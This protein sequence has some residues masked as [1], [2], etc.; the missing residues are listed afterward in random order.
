MPRRARSERRTF[1]LLSGVTSAAPRA[2]CAS[3][4]YPSWT[5]KRTC[6]KSGLRLG[7]RGERRV[8]RAGYVG[9]GAL[10]LLRADEE[11]GRGDHV[12]LLGALVVCVDHR[13]REVL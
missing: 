5:G 7:L 6:E 2:I 10:E 12:D 9:V 3:A 4:R 1:E 8:Q 13:H 11:R